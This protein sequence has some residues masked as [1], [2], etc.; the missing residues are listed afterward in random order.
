[1]LNRRSSHVSGA[2]AEKVKMSDI[3]KQLFGGFHTFRPVRPVALK[4]GR[5]GNFD[6]LF[7]VIGF[8][9]LM[10]VL[11]ELVAIFMDMLHRI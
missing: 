6:V 3:C 4:L 1:M 2:L 5:I 11:Y 7:L 10:Y 8:D 9:R